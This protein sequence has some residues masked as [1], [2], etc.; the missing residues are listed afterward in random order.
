MGH[1]RVTFGG[2]GKPGLTCIKLSIS[3][4]VELGVKDMREIV[5]ALAFAYPL[6]FRHRIGKIDRV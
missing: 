2:A 6:M 4:C 1:L 3:H 5:V